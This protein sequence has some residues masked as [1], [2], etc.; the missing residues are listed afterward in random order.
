NAGKVLPTSD[1]EKRFQDFNSLSNRL[2]K[3]LAYIRQDER[4][5][6]KI[7]IR[8]LLELLDELQ[9]LKTKLVPAEESKAA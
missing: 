4:Q 5:L 8:V 7:D 1:A 6:E 2:V 9:L 3:T